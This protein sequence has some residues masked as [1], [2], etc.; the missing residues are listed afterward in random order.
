[1]LGGALNICNS[2]ATGC[3]Y[4]QIESPGILDNFAKLASH[5][6]LRE[7][8]LINDAN[9]HILRHDRGHD[10]D[11]GDGGDALFAWLVASEHE[12]AETP[13]ALNKK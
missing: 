3:N 7:S 2:L 5:Q 12:C 13:T 4:C 10:H 9:G 6:V 11:G 8:R 1:M